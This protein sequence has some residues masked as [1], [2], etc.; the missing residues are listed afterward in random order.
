M[1][2]LKD[3]AFDLVDQGFFV[4]PLTRNYKPFADSVGLHDASRDVLTVERMFNDKRARHIGVNTGMSGLIILDI[5][6]KNGKDG[7]EEIENNWLDLPDTFNYTTK[8]NG[9]HYVFRAP[10]KEVYYAPATNYRGMAGVDRR[11][12]GS[13]VVWY[14]DRAPVKGEVKKAPDW[15]CDITMQS[16]LHP[17]EGDL[18]E[19]IAGL[20]PGKPSLY[21]RNAMEKVSEIPDLSHSDMVAAQF[22]AVRLGAEGHSGVPELLELIRTSWLGRDPA[23]HT[24]PE[25]EWADKYD[26][27]LESAIE[28]YGAQTEALSSLPEF[29]LNAIPTHVLDLF[30]G[31]GESASN[32]EWRKGMTAMVEANIPDEVVASALWNAPRT[33]ELSREWGIDFVFQRIDGAKGHSEPERENPTLVEVTPDSSNP[34]AILRPLLS[35]DEKSYISTRPCWADIYLDTLEELGF[36]NRTLARPAAW[37]VAS[38]A[39]AFRGFIPKSGTDNMGLNLWFLTLGFSGTGKTRSRK[40]QSAVLKVLFEGDNDDAWFSLGEDSSIQGLNLSLLHR[41]RQPSILD[42][43]EASGFFERLKSNDWMTGMDSQFAHW[44]EGFVS[45]SNKLNLKDMRGKSALTSFNIHMLATPDRMLS[46]LTRDM[47][48]TGFLARFNWV[49][50]DPPV[51]HDDRFTIQQY[52]GPAVGSGVEMVGPQIIQLAADLFECAESFGPTPVPIYMTRDAQ[53]RMSAAYRQ[54]FRQAE[55][56][57][58][59]DIIEPSITR[60]SETVHKI[61][62]IE[63]M[64]NG[65]TEIELS[66]ALIAINEVQE[67]YDNLFEVAAEVSAGEFQRDVDE[68]EAY[69][70]GN[71]TVTHAALY[72]RFRNMVVKS[73]RELDDRVE[74]L[75]ASGRINRKTEKQVVKYVING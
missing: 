39:F 4:F 51:D 57:E 18:D 7:F 16:N 73:R 37:T 12:G 26:E 31:S 9:A 8:N 3:I 67:W 42:I 43:D 17:Y 75:I 27:A 14:A 47:F 20:T 15:L 5:D 19:W 54:M 66:D 36:V 10:D 34:H 52:D 35:N 1:A 60:L 41:D 62:A 46:T 44:Y 21:V 56:K 49:L 64:Y 69:V 13:Y 58:N 23:L 72:H 38:M 40:A 53:D 50:G 70:R 61:A 65:R 32:F 33:K 63:A 2:T 71:K 74:F 11:S 68:M 25:I 30:T 59:W 24:T 29:D 22:N 28:K 45:P 48:Q 6:R 55:G